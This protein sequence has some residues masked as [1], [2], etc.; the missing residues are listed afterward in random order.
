MIDVRADTLELLRTLPYQVHS[1]RVDPFKEDK[2]PIINVQYAKISRQCLSHD[3]TFRAVASLR[4]IVSV[5]KTTGY[6]VLLDTVVGEVLDK[7]LTDA[8]WDTRYEAVSEILTEYDYREAGETN[9]AAALI[10]FEIQYTDKYEPRIV[11]NLES[12]HVDVDVISP[13]ADPLPGPDGR[14]E[15]SFDVDIN[16]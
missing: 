11:N 4:V 14:I 5:C 2:T 1:S 8:I 7:L 6:D 12:I 13:A 3:L 16:Q 15:A 9:Q 10:T